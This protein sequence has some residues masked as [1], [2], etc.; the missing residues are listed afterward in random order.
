M[1][2]KLAL[3]ESSSKL[4]MGLPSPEAVQIPTSVT[5]SPVDAASSCIH[6][7]TPDRPGLLLEI[8]KVLT[9]I[10]VQIKSADIHTEVRTTGISRRNGT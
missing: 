1:T 6:V 3:Q 2:F 7:E 8:V 9:D 4:A 5:V 10:S